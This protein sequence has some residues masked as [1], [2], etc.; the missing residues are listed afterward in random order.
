MIMD[1]FDEMV[2]TSERQPLVMGLSRHGDIV[3]QPFRLR[4]LRE[5]LTRCIRHTLGERV[6]FTRAGDIADDCFKLP[7]ATILGS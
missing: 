7:E 1:Q 6:W 4:A 5:A 3:G 2:E